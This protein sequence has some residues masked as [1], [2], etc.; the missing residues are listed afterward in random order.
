MR[1]RGIEE[2]DSGPLTGARIEEE[3]VGPATVKSR[4]PGGKVLLTKIQRCSGTQV[5]F[6]L[7]G[8]SSP[9]DSLYGYH[10]K[11]VA[12]AAR[13]IGHFA[14]WAE[15]RRAHASALEV[16]DFLPV[17]R[18]TDLEIGGPRYSEKPHAW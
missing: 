1:R 9:I 11:N 13:Q 10:Q 4:R 14:F 12:R 2:K 5:L 7:D 16:C 17:S 3:E 6:T 18:R 15:Q 8:L